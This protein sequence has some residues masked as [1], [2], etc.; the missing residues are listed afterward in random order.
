MEDEAKKGGVLQKIA[1]NG[2]WRKLAIAVGLIGIAL[3]FLSGFLTGG[4]SQQT[5]QP[6]ASSQSDFSAS[7]YESRMEKQMTELVTGIQG[8]GNAKVYV[9]LEQTAQNVYATEQKQSGQTTEDKSGGTTT[10]N[11]INSDTE[12]S[13]ILVKNADG[14]EKALPV[15]EIQPIVQ[16][17][18]V[19]CDGGDSPQVQQNIT[20]A[21][22]TALHI[23]SVRVCVI[24]AK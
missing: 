14:S 4:G 20:D 15:T 21:V 11:E 13:Y 7:D 2:N 16:G 12:T 18:V 6:S 1:G 17:V 10:R 8:V 9:T 23:T 5:Q 19:V 22:T 24:K 3:I